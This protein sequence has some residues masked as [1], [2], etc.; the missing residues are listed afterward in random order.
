MQ[1]S[2]TFRQMDA[3]DALKG[4]A[5]EKLTRL[6]KYFHDP[7]NVRVTMSTER[8]NHRVDVNVRAANGMSLAGHEVTENMYSSIDMVMAKLERQVRRYK[9]KLR[10]RRKPV[11]IQPAQISHTLFVDSSVSSVSAEPV[12]TTTPKPKVLE[13]KQ[14]TAEAMSTSDAIM[15]MNLNHKQFYVFLNDETGL[16][17]VI[18]RQEN[19]NEYGLIEARTPS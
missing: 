18:Y 14:L 4:Y 1:F 6:E 12:D 8:H 15:H 11:T 13:T 19:D 10:T 2:V 17:N 16:V 3:T 9:S 7:L 5:E